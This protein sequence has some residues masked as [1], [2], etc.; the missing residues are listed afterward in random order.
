[1]KYIK[2]FENNLY[3]KKRIDELKNLLNNPEIVKFKF[4]GID[5][6]YNRENFSTFYAVVSIFNKSYN[7]IS[8]DYPDLP[9]LSIDE[10]P[11]DNCSE[12]G[13][14]PGFMGTIKEVAELLNEIDAS[15]SV[16]EYLAS[17][18]YNL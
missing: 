5:N 15:G 3:I 2:I 1:M 10:F 9:G 14:S 8:S 17:K 13:Y 6:N 12:K 18:K 4:G 11:V 7:I 16:E